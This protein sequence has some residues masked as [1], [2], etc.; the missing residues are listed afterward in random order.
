MR[1]PFAAALALAASSLLA[2]RSSVAVVITVTTD[3]DVDAA[4]GFCSLR[5]AI[6]AA[7]ADAAVQECPAGDGADR[8]VFGLST[9]A[10]ILL[11]ADLPAFTETA[12]VQGPGSDL[13]T[14]DGQNLRQAFVFSNPT[15][16]HWFALEHLTVAH[17]TAVETGG[18]A[19]VDEEQTARFVGVRFLANQSG[20]SGGGLAVWEL[21]TAIVE[22]CSFEDNVAAGPAGGGG[23]LVVEGTLTLTGSALVG[24]RTTH[25][26][27]PGGGLLNAR[28]VVTIDRSTISG[29]RSNA[30]GGGVAAT[31]SIAPATLTVVDSTIT[32]NVADDDATGGADEGGGL[33]TLSSAFAVVS[34]AMTN[35]IVAGNLDS[36]PVVFDYPDVYLDSLT[37]PFTATGWNLVGIN[38]G[39]SSQFPAGLP[40]ANGDFVGT[41]AAPAAALLDALALNGGTT[42]NH[43]PTLDP[44]SLV[45][46]HGA[47]P[48]VQMD[49]RGSG[50]APFH[51]RRMPE[52]AVPNHPAS[53][54]CDIGAI[55][56]GASGVTGR[57]IFADDFEL[58]HD[59]LWSAATP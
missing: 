52:P 32:G 33:S 8:I 28:G 25:V 56:Y 11:A 12:A 30:R 42:L 5:E 18:G 38:E 31:S 51:Q 37:P 47:C 45:I 48:G 26:N 17:A 4:D 35:T 27:A 20:N 13:L 16:N 55:E 22:S 58:G 54:G 59:L 46:D 3:Q 21:A 34:V 57:A 9:P 19:M 36:S 43:Q 1:R 23:V 50:N 49:Q 6:L 2:A 24:N 29:N 44:A 40:N 14:I 39:S 53:D 7:N 41:A 10:T 15:S